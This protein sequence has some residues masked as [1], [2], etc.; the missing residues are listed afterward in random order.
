MKEP[1][2]QYSISNYLEKLGLELDV[3]EFEEDEC[4]KEILFWFSDFHS[5]YLKKKHN[6]EGIIALKGLPTVIKSIK[7]AIKRI[8]RNKKDRNS[9]KRKVYNDRNENFIIVKKRRI[10]KAN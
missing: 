8:N 6:V 5:P 4:F 7:E 3:P 1:S 10:E 9:K 2:I